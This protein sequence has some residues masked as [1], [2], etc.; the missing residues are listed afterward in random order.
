MTFEPQTVI[1]LISALFVFMG[2]NLGAMQWL[3]NRHDAVRNENARALTKNREYIATVETRLLELR[4]ELPME[5]V[6]REDWI[7]ISNTLEA[8]LDAMRAELREEQ[9]RM[10]GEMMNKIG[11]LGSLQRSAS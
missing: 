1:A 7:R 9:Q 8:K 10:R 5:Y 3:L 11:E 6:R 2:L 4:A